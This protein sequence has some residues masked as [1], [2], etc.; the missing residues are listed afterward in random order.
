[1]CLVA[2]PNDAVFFDLNGK[3]DKCDLCVASIKGGRQPVCV[4]ACDAGALRLVNL[5]DEGRTRRQAAAAGRR[6]IVP[7]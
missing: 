4:E 6:R 2:C 3:S 5:R 7:F 1:M